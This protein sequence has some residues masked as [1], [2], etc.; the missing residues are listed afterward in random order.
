MQ[1]GLPLVKYSSYTALIFLYSV[2]VVLEFNKQKTRTFSYEF[3][4]TE[5]NY[6]DLNNN[7]DELLIMKLK[8]H[9]HVPLAFKSTLVEIIENKA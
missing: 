3:T 7:I 9:Y 8:E 1:S 5:Q 2:D 6:M 4:V